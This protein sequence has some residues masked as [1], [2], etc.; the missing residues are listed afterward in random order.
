[1]RGITSFYF[2]F[3]TLSTVGYGDITPVADVARMLAAA[4]AVIGTLFVAVLIS[5]LVSMYSTQSPVK[6]HAD[7]N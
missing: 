4:E 1:M 3:V 7:K 2:S 5:R 6:E